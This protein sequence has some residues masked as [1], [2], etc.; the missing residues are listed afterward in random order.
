MYLFLLALLKVSACGALIQLRTTSKIHKR[1]AK[2]VQQ[3]LATPSNWPQIVLSSWAVKGS[4]TTQQQ[5]LKAND[6]VDETFGLPPIL[7]LSISWTCIKSNPRRGLLDVRSQQGVSGLACNCRMLFQIDELEQD[8]VRVDLTVEYEPQ[9]LLGILAI[10]VLT[11]DNAIAL[12][13]LLP[14]ALNRI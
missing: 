6:Q 3:F 14:I 11:I 13:I 1:T 2:Q 7:P 10:P 5:P 9:N 8:V 12:K 4:S